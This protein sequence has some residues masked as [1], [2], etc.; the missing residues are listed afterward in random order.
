MD[1]DIDK[2]KS[3]EKLM[4]KFIEQTKFKLKEPEKIKVFNR[5]S[6]NI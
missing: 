4:N 5:L 1:N 6:F 2:R 3:M